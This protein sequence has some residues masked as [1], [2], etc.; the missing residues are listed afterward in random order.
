EEDV[1]A[2]V[3]ELTE[4][5]LAD[6][7]VDVAAYATRPVVDAVEVV[8]PRGTIVLAGLKGANRPIPG[9]VSGQVV[10][11]PL[12]IKGVLGVDRPADARAIRI[13]ESG[14]YPLGRLHTHDF[15]LA[16]AALAVRTLAGD[17]PGTAPIHVVIRPEA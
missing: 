15:G 11:E 4:G 14:R 3:R 9:F 13:I 2:R 5:R 16:D 10:L 17:I 12:T 8:R 7:V 1:V 6:V